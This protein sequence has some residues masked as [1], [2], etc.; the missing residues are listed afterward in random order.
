MKKSPV[1]VSVRRLRGGATP[2]ANGHIML[3]V[4]WNRIKRRVL[5]LDPAFGS[6]RATLK[7]Y[8]LTDFLNAWSRSSNLAYVPILGR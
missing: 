3:V 4:G 2:Y 6:N 5:C 1:A 7:S 8:R